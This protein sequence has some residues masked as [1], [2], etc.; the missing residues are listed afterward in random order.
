MFVTLSKLRRCF[1]AGEFFM[2]QL[3]EINFLIR[4]KSM[5]E[6]I[7]KN[8]MCSFIDVF[9]ME[10]KREYKSMTYCNMSFFL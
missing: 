3:S 9:W 1:A 2:A 8:H 4:K 5:N 7:E 10:F 6:N